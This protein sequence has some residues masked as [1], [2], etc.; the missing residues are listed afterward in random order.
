MA[1]FLLGMTLSGLLL[2]QAVGITKSPTSSATSVSTTV[3]TMPVPSTATSE[4]GPVAFHSIM[5]VNSWTAVGFPAGSVRSTNLTSGAVSYANGVP[6]INDQRTWESWWYGSIFSC[7]PPALWWQATSSKCGSI[8]QVD[9]KT[10]TI[11]L[12]SPGASTYGVGF[13]LTQVLSVPPD[14]KIPRNSFSPYSAGYLRLEGAYISLAP[15]VA[16]AAIVMTPVVII[17][18]PKTQLPAILLYTVQ[19]G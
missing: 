17:D 13:N 1:T 9:F 5:F 19:A 11:L 14:P 8:P 6:E 16:Y 2:Q 15:E 4:W 18:I 7:A 12:V 10:R 3:T